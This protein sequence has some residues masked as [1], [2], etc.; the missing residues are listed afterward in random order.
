MA[1]ALETQRCSGLTPEGG[2]GRG[3]R[4]GVDGKGSHGVMVESRGGGYTGRGGSQGAQWGLESLGGPPRAGTWAHLDPLPPS[5]GGRPALLQAG[6]HVGGALLL[7]DHVSLDLRCR[8]RDL[9][10][11]RTRPEPSR[12]HHP[13]LS[14]DP[15]LS[16][17]L[18]RRY[19]CFH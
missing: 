8:G 5:S 1:S 18:L 15:G 3:P 17:Q 13:T 14:H 10:L 7:P 9:F 2:V 16:G 19:P 4:E 6:V 11:G 12:V